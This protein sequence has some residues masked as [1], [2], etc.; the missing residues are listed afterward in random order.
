MFEHFL[1]FSFSEVDVQ[2]DYA[3]GGCD[4]GVT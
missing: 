3:C 1:F 4:R 2:T